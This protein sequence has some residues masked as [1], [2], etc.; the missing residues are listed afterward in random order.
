MPLRVAVVGA[1]N[2]GNIHGSV[3]LKDSLAELVGYCDVIPE[4]AERSAT[5]DG[6][7]AALMTA[8]CPGWMEIFPAKP[9]ATPS[10]HSRL[11]PSRSGISVYTVSTA[12]TPAAAAATAHITRAWRGISR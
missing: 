1:G 8:I 11:N 12:S 4:K 10:W 7:N 6:V 3:Y 9:I 5:R 2:I